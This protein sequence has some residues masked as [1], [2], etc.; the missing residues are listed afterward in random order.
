LSC[1]PASLTFLNL[2]ILTA[3]KVTWNET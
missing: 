1:N 2:N 3:P